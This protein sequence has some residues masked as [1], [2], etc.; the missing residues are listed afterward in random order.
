MTIIGICLV[1]LFTA[2]ITSSL[3]G[4]TNNPQEM[5]PM[6]GHSIGVLHGS[7]ERL[8]VLYEGGK[9]QRM[10]RSLNFLPLRVWKIDDIYRKNTGF[11]L[12]RKGLE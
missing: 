7:A 8:R 2:S 10:L 6:V 12:I 11:I 3:S 1:S 4:I 9:P 5:N